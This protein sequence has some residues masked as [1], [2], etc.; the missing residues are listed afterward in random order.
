MEGY[1]LLGIRRFS[2]SFAPTEDSEGSGHFVF[3][4]PMPPAEAAS[5]ST[6]TL[7]GPEGVQTIDR[8][9]R[10]AP[11]ALVRDAATGRI[12]AILRDAAPPTIGA[13]EEVAVSTGLPG[14][15]LGSGLD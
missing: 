5:L 1:D 15:V 10:L 12:R 8:S 6:I 14:P 7:A 11:V 13:G 3:A 4:V 2:M 9:T